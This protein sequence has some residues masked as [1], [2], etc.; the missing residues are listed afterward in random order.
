MYSD[1]KFYEK[2]DEQ[3]ENYFPEGVKGSNAL[4]ENSDFSD[5]DEMNAW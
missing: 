1:V 2:D 4:I 5:F 3:H